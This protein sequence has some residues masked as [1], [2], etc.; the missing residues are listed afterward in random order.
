MQSIEEAE[1]FA[2]SISLSQ[3]KS[4]CAQAT[5][6]T[7]VVRT[8]LRY[9]SQFDR[10]S[11]TPGARFFWPIRLIVAPGLVLVSYSTAEAHAFGTPYSLPVPFWLYGYGACAALILSF[12]IVVYFV[13]VSAAPARA[14][15]APPRN[16][17]VLGT[18]TLWTLRAGSLAALLLSIIAGLIG[19]RDASVNINMTLFWIVFT[20]A[21]YYVT[22][23][24]GGLYSIIN[25]WRAI[26]T[27]IE[28]LAPRAFV[29]RIHYPELLSY[30]PAL[31]LYVAFI[32]IEL[33]GET[34]PRSLAFILIAYTAINVAAAALVGKEAWFTFGEFFS[35]L[36]RLAGMLAPIQYVQMKGE[37]VV[38][39]RLRKPLAACWDQSADRFALLLFILFAL[40]STAFDGFHETQPWIA[41]FWLDVYP[42]LRS[43]LDRPYQELVVFYHYWQWAALMLSPIFYLVVYLAFVY[44]AKV[45]AGSKISL[46]SL[47]LA[48]AY[49]LVPVAV[50]YHAAHYF[51][52]VASQGTQIVRMISDSF[53]FGWNLFGT[54]RWLDTPVV[55][56]AGTVWHAQVGLIVIGHALGVYVAHVKALRIFA[57]TRRALVSQLPM[58]FLM[59]VFT[60]V[61]LWILSLPIAGGNVLV[62]SG[63]A[64]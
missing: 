27:C 53:G 26:C 52:L 59:M 9:R 21:F 45:L 11:K 54:A 64:G 6:N 25:P 10:R 60:T 55:L 23:F 18:K 62:P 39:V 16:C 40:S 56:A 12:L 47:A 36:F 13:D 5:R 50:A 4:A 48:F 43:L 38:H 57:T 1:S 30:W 37:H 22:P 51:S 63:D 61:G 42:V 32:W 28:S 14:A 8:A 7:S 46:A 31:I 33:F 20:L 35:I 15:A 58:L 41:I 2:S 44:L 29:G 17:I 3:E 49:S 34:Q 24:I 19:T